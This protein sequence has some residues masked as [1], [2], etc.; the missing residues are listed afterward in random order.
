M[1]QVRKEIATVIP[2]AF[3]AVDAKKHG[4]QD[5]DGEF[6][7]AAG[8]VVKGLQGWRNAMLSEWEDA[9]AGWSPAS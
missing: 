3:E 1:R 2:F 8:T 4:E 6:R 9:V 5:Y 7:T